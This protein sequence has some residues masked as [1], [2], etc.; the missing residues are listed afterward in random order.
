MLSSLLFKE[1]NGRIEGKKP[2]INCNFKGKKHWMISKEGNI[3]GGTEKNLI[4]IGSITGY[5]QVN[6]PLGKSHIFVINNANKCE[7]RC[8]LYCGL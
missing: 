8:K 3:D 6:H 5:N 1:I 7:L 2:T 4:L